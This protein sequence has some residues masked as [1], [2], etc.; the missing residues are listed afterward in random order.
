MGGAS[1]TSG[2]PPPSPPPADT[3]AAVRVFG[4]LLIT[5]A[6]TF[7][8][9]LA[10]V[11]AGRQLVWPADWAAGASTWALWTAPYLGATLLA[12]SVAPSLMTRRWVG[13]GGGPWLGRRAGGRAGGRGIDNAAHIACCTNP[14]LPWGVEQP[15]LS[16]WW[17]AGRD[18]GG[19]GGTSH[20]IGRGTGRERR[21]LLPVRWETRG[22]RSSG[23]SLSTSSGAP[24]PSAAHCGRLHG[25][26]CCRPLRGANVN[27]RFAGDLGLGALGALGLTLTLCQVGAGGQAG[28]GCSML[29]A[30]TAGWLLAC[31]LN[32]QM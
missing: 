11:D 25:G 31:W 10:G 18:R 15:M 9:S 21:P 1:F 12:C 3:L 6:L 2:A 32:Q 29:R 28:H 8:G 14:V 24:P 19:G 23:G 27:Q 13:A 16:P 4:S 20:G 5:T 26:A 30:H 22:M 7:L 17:V